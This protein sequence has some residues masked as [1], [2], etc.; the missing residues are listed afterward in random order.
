MAEPEEISLL[1]E[2]RQLATA[3]P[4]VPFTIVMASGREYQIGPAVALS[5]GRSTITM[6]LPRKGFHL[7][8]ISQISETSVMAEAP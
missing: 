3:E 2:I 7:L 8:R 1:D 6:A 5:I 4:F